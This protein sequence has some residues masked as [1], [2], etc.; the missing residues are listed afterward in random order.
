MREINV[1]PS[2]HNIY[3]IE[4]WGVDKTTTTKN[5]KLFFNNNYNCNMFYF[6]NDGWS[7]LLC[8]QSKLNLVP[9]IV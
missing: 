4:S 8:R 5:T 2:R 6:G 9:I 7:V 1:S 3:G